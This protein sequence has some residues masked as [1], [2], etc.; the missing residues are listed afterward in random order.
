M[1]VLAAFQEYIDSQGLFL[2]QDRILLAVSGGKDSV[3]MAHLFSKA[4]FSFA[5]AHCNFQLRGAESER[6]EAFVR[7]FAQQLQVPVFV[8]R[9]ETKSYAENNQVS[10]QMAA[11]DLRYHWFNS[12]CEAEDFDYIASAHHQNDAMETLLWNL[13]RGTGI[14]GLHGILPKRKNLVRPLM[15]LT[16]EQI[17]K[18]VYQEKLAFVEDSSNAKTDYSRNLIRHEVVPVLKQLNPKLEECFQENIRRFAEIEQF[19]DL[20]VE[21]LKVQFFAKDEGGIVYFNK[22]DALNL[23]PIGLLLFQLLKPYGFSG[24]NIRDIIDCLKRGESGRYFEN[25]SFQL[26]IDRDKVYLLPHSGNMVEQLSVQLGD[27]NFGTG[28]LSFVITEATQDIENSVQNA[29]FKAGEGIQSQQI[30]LD[31]DRLE[32]PLQ[33]RYYRPGDKFKPLGMQGSKKISDFFIGLKIPQHQKHRIPLLCDAQD[34]IVWVIPYRMDN[35]YKITNDTKKV[36]IF[37]WNFKHGK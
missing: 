18:T 5:I 10:I 26:R 11:R 13:V 29:G 32:F 7:Q 14:A 9:F 12:L 1:N 16:A 19:L 37:E 27:N 33:L 6:D 25:D 3:L 36:A 34:R 17:E 21:S 4:G 24:T 31:A 23:N 35:H 8:K 2:P 15:F 22:Q 30:R 28:Y 20:Q